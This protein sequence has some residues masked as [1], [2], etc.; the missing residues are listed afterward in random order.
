MV[1]T[2]NILSVLA[3]VSACALFA[4]AIR[5]IRHRDSHGV[6]IGVPSVVESFQQAGSDNTRDSGHQ[7]SPLVQ[8]AERFAAYLNPPRPPERNTTTRPREKGKTVAKA[9]PVRPANTTPK[10]ELHGISYRR[11]KPEQSM[12]LIWQADTGRRWVRPGA[13]L[14]HIA[15][16]EI[17]GDSVFYSDGQGTKVMA[18][19]TS[20]TRAT[21]ARG[22]KEKP[23]PQQSE[24]PTHLVTRW[25][26]VRRIRQIPAA[27]VAARLGGKTNDT[28]RETQPH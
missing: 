21:F 23:A 3:L 17:T 10:F 11:S 16:V 2:L 22:L 8:Q 4:L 7:V 19:D 1:R 28:N 13:Q 12:A 20:Q 6:D 25:A 14:G 18:L 27:R 24:K 15:I 26:P 9:S 5:E